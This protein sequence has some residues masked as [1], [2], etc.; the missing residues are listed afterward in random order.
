MPLYGSH[1]FY[2]SV[3]DGIGHSNGVFLFNSNPMDVILQPKPA[4]TWRT[5]GGVLDF[6][7]LLG[8]QPSDVIRQYTQ[9]VGSPH[10]P[11]YWALGF[12]L[13]KF[14]YN[15][16]DNMIAVFN[17]TRSAGIPYDVQVIIVEGFPFRYE[18]CF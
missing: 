14:G 8:P 18:F 15:S 12:H 5:I 1:P 11:P 16:L 7:V 4:I 3:E 9:L 10:L 13:C 2:L 6:Y 17:R